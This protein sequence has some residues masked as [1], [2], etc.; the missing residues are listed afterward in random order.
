MCTPLKQLSRFCF[1]CAHLTSNCQG[2][3]VNVHTSQAIVKVLF[4]TWTPL[5]QLTAGEL[6]RSGV[7]PQPPHSS[8]PTPARPTPPLP[9]Q[10]THNTP[11]NAMTA[12]HPPTHPPIRS[13][14]W[15]P[16]A[17]HARAMHEKQGTQSEKSLYAGELPGR[18]SGAVHTS[19][20]VVK[21]LFSMCTPHKQLS[22]FCSQCAH[23]T[24]NCQGF[25]LNV[26][27][28]QAIVKVLHMCTPLE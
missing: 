20:A 3:A 8:S 25:A 6:P 14:M 9:P 13:R 18:C 27:T 24:S 16:C 5:K 21:V 28:S 15:I 2:F 10:Y 17:G 26:H 12:A 11:R 7:R 4:S 23:L 1:Q 19:Q 22:R